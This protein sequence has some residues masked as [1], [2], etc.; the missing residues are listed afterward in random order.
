[1]GTGSSQTVG[2]RY[3]LGMHLGICHGPV[4]AVLE[5][6]A[7]GRQAWGDPQNG[8]NSPITESG[9]GYINQYE[10]FGGEEREGGILGS[11][12]V[13][14]GD[15]DQQI[16][17]YLAGKETD[18]VGQPT[19]SPGGGL[20]T[21]IINEPVTGGRVTGR[22]SGY[23][24]AYRG[25]L[26][27]VWRGGMVA[28]NNPY[29]KPW[30]FKVR[31]ILKGWQNNEAAWYPAKA[32][33]VLS[34]GDIAANPAHIVYECLTNQEWGMGYG[35]AQIN[36]TNFRAAADIFHAEGMG[37]CLKWVQ[38]D[39]IK[40][41]IQIVLDHAG[42]ALR[43][44]KRTGLFE[45]K[46]I[47]NDYTV[48]ELPLFDETNIVALESYQRPGLIDAINE[49]TVVYEDV[50]T[51]K[52]GSVTVQNLANITAQ[53][54]VSAKKQNYAGLAT[55]DLAIRVAMRDLQ[56]ISTPLAKVSFTVDR[57]AWN[58]LPGDVLRFAWGNLGVTD[59]VLRVLR[60]DTGTLS[61]GK[62]R[63]D[64]VQDVFGL[65]A[66]GYA[67]QPPVG[68]TDPN[69]LPAP[70]ANRVV[71]EASYYALGLRMS[72]EDRAALPD[73]AGFLETVAVRPSSDSIFYSISTDD[74]A[75]YEQ[76]GRGDFAPS[77][78][79][80]ENIGSDTTTVL[81]ENIVDGELVET[82]K[83]AYLGDEIIRVDGFDQASGTL[84]MGRGVMDSVATPHTT[85]ARVYFA[86]DYAEGTSTERIDGESVAVKILPTTGRGTLDIN[87]APAD[88]VVF[89]QRPF[90]PYPPGRFRIAGEA[91]PE[92]LNS[93]DGITV[94][95]VHRNRLQQNLEGDESGN[96]GPETGVLYEIRMYNNDTNGLFESASAIEGT[97]FTFA[98]LP[99]D[100]YN[101]RIEL[102][103][104]RDGLES[105]QKHSH[106]FEYRNIDNRTTEAGDTRVTE[107]GDTRILE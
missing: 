8:D 72:A 26:S 80:K 73:D 11:F 71:G 44:H 87:N 82:G 91:H 51:G 46:A 107:A 21:P 92:V 36:D 90:R 42:A 19:V 104:V 54:G 100:N 101:L 93:Q 77:A 49:L 47:R 96:I 16:N 97:S 65:P 34:S 62:I 56:A 12:D 66:T 53:G 52:E 95:W 106:I 15:L 94:T 64:A 23:E 60:I 70:A 55:S 13:M 67:K 31:R 27:I 25:I 38:Q 35:A 10:L 43:Q 1:M 68:W 84:T 6:S 20:W 7:G 24:T 45:I 99:P 39:Q 37:L 28:C 9:R 58:V 29:I 2:Y 3:Y 18:I 33:I 61:N 89:D 57:K 83:F 14:M 48:A 85:G 98:K 75:G 50:T 4:D 88:T 78:T 17:A 40:N 103:S 81:V 102:W 59:L 79:I 63:I 22:P 32:E 5:I 74:G 41:F 76:V 86:H 69:T 30:A 105:R